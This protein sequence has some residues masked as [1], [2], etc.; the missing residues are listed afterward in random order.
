MDEHLV[1]A[2]NMYVGM[3]N[4]LPAHGLR[5]RDVFQIIHGNDPVPLTALANKFNP[6]DRE[7]KLGKEQARFLAKTVIAHTREL[8]TSLP[9]ALRYHA[10]ELVHNALPTRDRMKYHVEGLDVRCAL[11]GEGVETVGHLHS[12]CR[13]SRSAMD[14]IFRHSVDKSAVVILRTA[15]PDDFLFRSALPSTD[16]LTL[17]AF[18]LAVW[19]TRANY[20]QKTHRQSFVIQA[21]HSIATLSFLCG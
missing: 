4:A 14:L 7:R 20:Y 21:A 10:F 9:P 2:K 8:P 1:Q 11:C 18:S 5:A 19:R 12:V 15:Q 13:A 6:A 16:R 3:V 17:L